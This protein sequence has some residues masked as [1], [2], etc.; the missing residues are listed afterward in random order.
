MTM[1]L[2]PLR[3]MAITFGLVCGFGELARAGG[4]IDTS[5]PF[6][7][8]IDNDPLGN[9]FTASIPYSTTPTTTDSGILQISEL[10]DPVNASTV[11]IQFTLS[12]TTGAPLV[13]Q[14]GS[15]WQ[16]FI[17]NITTTAP[18]TLTAFFTTFVQADG[19]VTPFPFDTGTIIPN[20]PI[21]GQVGPVLYGTASQGPLTSQYLYAEMYPFN[22]D[23]TDF[24]S[25]GGLPVPTTWIIGGEFQLTSVPEPA[26][27]VLLLLGVVGAGGYTLRARVWAK[28]GRPGSTPHGGRDRRVLS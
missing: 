13:G 7:L 12:T 17:E 8:S 19:T 26:G 15:Y 6:T 16:S 10:I 27:S 24:G 11:W 25:P 20:N 9:N 28:S 5:S 21:P 23:P 2:R 14:P 1:T 3:L 4:I 18:T 22:Q